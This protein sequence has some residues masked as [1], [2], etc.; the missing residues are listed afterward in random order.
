[1]DLKH[2][3]VVL[4]SVN[5]SDSTFKS[6]YSEFSLLSV[7]FT[8]ENNSHSWMHSG[9]SGLVFCML[10]TCRAACHSAR[11]QNPTWRMRLFI[12]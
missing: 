9:S 1:M 11:W 3:F 7:G 2:Y 8:C 5:A 4:N 10:D 6:A 12:V